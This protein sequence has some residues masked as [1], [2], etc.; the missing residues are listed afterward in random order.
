MDAQPIAISNEVSDRVVLLLNRYK[1]PFLVIILPALLSAAFLYGVVA[2]QYI[3]EAH[4][5]VKKAEEGPAMPTGIGQALSLVGGVTEGHSEAASVSDYLTSM[6]VVE[7]LRKDVDLVAIFRRPEADFLSRMWH[8]DPQDEELLK[9]YRDQVSVKLD[10]STGIVTVRARAFRPI[11]S[12]SVVQSL[13]RAG[14]ERVNELNQR[15]YDSSLAYARKQMAE[16]ENGVVVAQAALTGFRQASS[17]LDPAASGEAQIKIV[18]GVTETLVQA[19]AALASMGATISHRSPQY[20]A[21]EQKVRALEGQQAA[22]AAVMT[23]QHPQSRSIAQ[24][25]GTYEQLKVKQDLAVKRYALASADLQKA[26]DRAEEKRIFLVPIVNAN[27]PEKALYP[28]RGRIVFT[29]L[30][31]MA[32]VYCIGWLLVAGVREHAA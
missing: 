11:D 7:R 1:W 32:V 14:E 20:I 10:S 16:A 25:L 4:F 28:E 13:L 21:L 19:R 6:N 18:S 5:L 22:E 23:R 29:V 30:G 24:N 2:D 27:L 12:R 15:A 31:I 26:T 9:Y 3:S 8:A 17:E